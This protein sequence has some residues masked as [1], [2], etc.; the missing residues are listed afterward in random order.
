MAIIRRPAQNKQQLESQPQEAPWSDASGEGAR[1]HEET[2]RATGKRLG[3]GNSSHLESILSALIVTDT[4]EADPA[5]LV[6]T[7]RFRPLPFA[8]VDAT[9]LGAGAASR[10]G[11]G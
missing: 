5:T 8:A 6:A 11:D 1:R 3:H 4:V 2:A 9:D 7:I 10:L